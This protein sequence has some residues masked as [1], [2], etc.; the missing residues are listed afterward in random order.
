MTYLHDLVEFIR[1]NLPDEHKAAF[2]VFEKQ[3]LAAPEQPIDEQ[4]KLLLLEYCGDCGISYGYRSVYWDF[5]MT[6]LQEKY[7]DEDYSEVD[8]HIPEYISEWDK[9][10]DYDA[11]MF[12]E[13]T[14]ALAFSMALTN[15]VNDNT[16]SSFC[17]AFKRMM[18]Q[19]TP[20][21]VD[22]DALL[23]ALSSYLLNDEEE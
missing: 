18:E 1:T 19:L 22:E 20:S 13:Q 8:K 7:P 9:F 16:L 5:A 3:L 21:D 17:Y 2:S 15:C 4:I 10:K 6:L 12:L 11:G 14:L 23:D